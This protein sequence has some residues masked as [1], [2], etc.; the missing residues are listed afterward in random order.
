MCCTD[1]NCHAQKSLLSLPVYVSSQQ[2]ISKKARVTLSPFLHCW[3]TMHNSQWSGPSLAPPAHSLVARSLS[4]LYPS[5][6]SSQPP[7]FKS[8]TPSSASHLFS[9][10][11]QPHQAGVSKVD[12]DAH[13]RT[14]YIDLAC[15]LIMCVYTALRHGGEGADG[16]ICSPENIDILATFIDIWKRYWKRHQ[17]I[18]D[19][20]TRRTLPI[21]K[22]GGKRIYEKLFEDAE[23]P[24]RQLK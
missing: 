1:E 19:L 11:L 20:D 13:I 3:A 8:A 17:R 22:K 7:P 6:S 4:L 15:I 9:R 10:E 2:H 21:H 18:L 23:Y 14:I 5:T 12:E 16:V 24:N